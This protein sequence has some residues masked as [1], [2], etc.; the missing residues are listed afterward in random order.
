[1][2]SSTEEKYSANVVAQSIANAVLWFHVISASEGGPGVT[3]SYLPKIAFS[4]ISSGLYQ[5]GGGKHGTSRSID[6]S[7]AFLA[8][9]HLPELAFGHRPGL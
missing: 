2:V 4:W 1:M 8:P 3:A 7:R 5:S 9:G 6:A